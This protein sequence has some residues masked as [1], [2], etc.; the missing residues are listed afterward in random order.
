MPNF[1]LRKNVIFSVFAFACNISLVFLSYRLMIRKSGLEAVGL[2]STLFAWTT[3]IRMGDAGMSNASLRFIALCDPTKDRERLRA[4]LETGLISNIVLFILLG[5]AGYLA[6]SLN[7]QNIVS[8][9]FIAEAHRVLPVMMAGFV[10]MNISGVLLGSLQGLHLGYVNSQLSI[11][12]N[13]VQII[14]VMALVPLY[15]VTGLAW[16]QVI[17]YSAS[18]LAAWCFVRRQTGVRSFVPS[19]FSVPVFKEMLGFSLKAQVANI[20]NGLF[21]PLSKILVG[22]VGG[23]QTVGVYELAFKTIS[24][25]RNV[26][27]S[28][29]TATLPAMTTLFSSD[30]E[31][32][33]NFYVKSVKFNILGVMS[34][35]TCVLISSPFISIFWI[36]HLDFQYVI[37]CALMAGGF[38]INSYGAPA[39]QMGVASGQMKNNIITTALA[40]ALLIGVGGVLGSIFGGTGVVAAA[41]GTLAVCGFLVKLLNERMLF[42]RIARIDAV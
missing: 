19:L 18:I 26:V 23:L 20:A 5:T 13:L 36:G 3:M 10:L 24:L 33:Q 12:G 14:A 2:W 25:T 15:G 40:I 22:H 9:K 32:I 7:I 1:N 37:Y 16:S 29:L 21:E 28:A 35:L 17:Q 31:K 8:H 41:S 42:G 39:Y 30:R 6:I 38:I 34:L 11:M 27:V 4:Y